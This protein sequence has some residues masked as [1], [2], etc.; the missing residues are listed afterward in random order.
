MSGFVSTNGML[1]AGVGRRFFLRKLRKAIS[2][3][4]KIEHIV[5]ASELTRSEAD[6][7][8]KAEIEARGG[9]Q[10]R[11]RQLWNTHKGGVGGAS[12]SSIYVLRKRWADDAEFRKSQSDRARETLQRT[13]QDPEIRARKVEANRRVCNSEYGLA[14]LEKARSCI[15]RK[16]KSRQMSDWNKQRWADPEYR[17]KRLEGLARGRLKRWGTK[18]DSH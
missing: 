6:S 7:L 4:R 12:P 5:L 18:C 1:V 14:R 13:L 2:E 15:D 16:L 17:K 11:G 3:N 10:K 9:H 8:E